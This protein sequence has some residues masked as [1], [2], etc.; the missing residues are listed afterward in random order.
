[1]VADGPKYRYCGSRDRQCA[2]C[3]PPR[4]PFA[5]L[6]RLVAFRQAGFREDHIAHQPR[7]EKTFAAARRDCGSGRPLE[8][9]AARQGSQHAVDRIAF[10]R[11]TGEIDD[12]QHRLRRTLRADKGGVEE[13]FDQRTNAVE[14]LREAVRGGAPLQIA[15]VLQAAEHFGVQPAFEFAELF[16]KALSRGARGRT[17]AILE[18]HAPDALP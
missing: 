8:P 9:E 11:A 12:A 6:E 4:Q 15:L 14:F 17:T 2:E 16:R 3:E 1:Q 13:L 18:S 5:A 10:L 7:E